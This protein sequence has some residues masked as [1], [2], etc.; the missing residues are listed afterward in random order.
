MKKLGIEKIYRHE[1]ALCELFIRELKKEKNIIIYRN[2]ECQYVPIV[3]FNIFGVM[4]EAAAQKFAEQGFCLRAGYHCAALAHASIGTENGTIRF[5]PSVFSTT[6]LF[7]NVAFNYFSVISFF[8]VC[9]HS[10]NCRY[11]KQ[12]A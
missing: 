6:H 10:F 4:P 7:F 8:V 2:P 3:S 1:T 9:S 5:S 12:I 11:I